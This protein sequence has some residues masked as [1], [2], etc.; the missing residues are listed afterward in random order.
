MATETSP[1]SETPAKKPGLLRI[2]CGIFF[3]IFCTIPLVMAA[4]RSIASLFS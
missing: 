4:L 2:G 1:T 3:L